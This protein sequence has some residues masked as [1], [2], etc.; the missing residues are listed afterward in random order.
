LPFRLV[1][2]NKLLSHPKKKSGRRVQRDGLSFAPISEHSVRQEVREHH[3][4][5]S[6]S[7]AEKSK[8]KHRRGKKISRKQKIE[9]AR[10]RAQELE[11]RLLDVPIPLRAEPIVDFFQ[12]EAGDTTQATVFGYTT[13]MPVEEAMRF[14]RQEME[15]NGWNC[16]SEVRG[17]ESLASYTKP[18]R[19]CSIATREMNVRTGGS[20][21]SQIIIF[22]G[23]A[24]SSA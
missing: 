10:K 18:G 21:S 15:R 11:A 1:L 2:L 19:L 13:D 3:A 6:K 20:A 14:Y 23:P 22:T 8:N 7:G 5:G 4:G 17:T 9:N 24:S 16:L 12:K